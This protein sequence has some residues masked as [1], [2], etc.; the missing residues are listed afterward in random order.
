MFSCATID[1]TSFPRPVLGFCEGVVYEIR[2]SPASLSTSPH[3]RAGALLGAEEDFYTFL[4]AA[5]SSDL[6]YL[7]DASEVREQ[8]ISRFIINFTSSTRPRWGIFE[9][10]EKRPCNFILS[11]KHI[12]STRWDIFPSHCSFGLVPALEGSW[13]RNYDVQ[14]IGRVRRDHGNPTEPAVFSLLHLCARAEVFWGSK[15][16]RRVLIKYE[17]I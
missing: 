16:E 7:T 4:C 11:L 6:F 10:G 15:G 8:I 17:I 13:M 12:G 5:W 9:S 3:S 2:I 1:S 14:E